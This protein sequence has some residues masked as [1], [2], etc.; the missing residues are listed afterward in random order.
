MLLLALAAAIPAGV[1]AWGLIA[2]VRAPLDTDLWDGGEYGPPPAPH[3]DD[4]V[5]DTDPD[6]GDDA[7]PPLDPAWRQEVW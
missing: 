2:T 4:T 7:E 5:D 3:L 6:E 1:I